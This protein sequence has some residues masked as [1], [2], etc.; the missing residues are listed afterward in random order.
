MKSLILPLLIFLG[1]LTAV[2][3]TLE[4]TKL[5]EDE[6]GRRLETKEKNRKVTALADQREVELKKAQEALTATVATRVAAEDRIANK[7]HW[8]SSRCSKRSSRTP[9]PRLLLSPRSWT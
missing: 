5:F 8:P 3:F 4:Q 6:Q 9:R 2:Y 1:S 7:I